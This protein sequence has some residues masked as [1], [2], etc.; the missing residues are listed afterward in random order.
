[1]KKTISFLVSTILLT[2]AT[3]TSPMAQEPS[4][5]YYIKQLTQNND[6]VISGSE[7]YYKNEPIE[8]QDLDTTT[9]G[10]GFI[11]SPIEYTDNDNIFS[12]SNLINTRA[13]LPTKYT[14]PYVTSVKDQYNSESCWVFGTL[15]AMESN[16]IKDIGYSNPDFSEEHARQAIYG[17]RTWHDPS[18]YKYRVIGNAGSAG[19]SEYVSRYILRENY[20]GPAEEDGKN[21]YFFNFASLL[22]IDKLDL[23]SP[24]EYYP[25]TTIKLP[26]FD[27]KNYTNTELNNRINSI[28]AA[29]YDGGGAVFSF[30]FQTGYMKYVYNYDTKQPEYYLNIAKSSYEST[31]NNTSVMHCLELIG[32]DDSISVDKFSQQPSRNGGFLVKNSWGAKYSYSYISYDNVDLM[33]DIMYF[34]DFSSRKNFDNLYEYDDVATLC[35]DT[36]RN[37]KKLFVTKFKKNTS[38]KEILESINLDVLDVNTKFKIYVSPTGSFSDLTPVKISNAEPAESS[39]DKIYTRNTAGNFTL[40]LTTPIDLTGNNFLIGIEYVNSQPVNFLTEKFHYIDGEDTRLLTCSPTIN[41][42][43]TYM[44]NNGAITS[45]D[46]YI[47]TATL[48]TPYNT[49]FKAYTKN[50]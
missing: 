30:P 9:K 28:K 40:D 32:W 48:S 29:I 35:T 50:H 15:A 24:I 25:K 37:N 38:N 18:E 16:I 17:S 36:N 6:M 23:L 14:S 26:Y 45:Q 22:T 39:D 10:T 27:Y 12:S 47:D 3:F 43:E 20:Y 7:I 44:Y 13:S 8:Q 49:C 4:N 21:L 2:T 19:N 1:M 31:L 33:Q 34:K 5:L 42:G 11:Q 41:T 46:S